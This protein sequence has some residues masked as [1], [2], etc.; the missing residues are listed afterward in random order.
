M[1]ATSFIS[2]SLDPDIDGVLSGIKWATP[3]LTFSFPTSGSFYGYLPDPAG[4]ETATFGLLD[5][6]AQAM[7]RASAVEKQTVLA[8]YAAVSGLIFTE[9]NESATIH[10]DLRYGDSELH[11]Q[12][13]AYYPANDVA[14]VGGD[15][16]MTKSPLF[17][18]PVKGNKAFFTYLHETG[19]ALGLKHGHETSLAT[20]IQ[21]TGFFDALP[22]SHDSMEYSVMTYRSFVGGPFLT[23]YSNATF[24]Y[25]QTLMQDDVAA[26]QYLYG[27][28]FA[29]NSGNSVYTWSATT[30]EMSING[31]AQGAPGSPTIFM[32]IWDGGGIDTYDLSTRTTNLVIN[33][34]PGGW[35]NLGAQLANL[36]LG[37]TAVGNISNSLLFQ[38]NTASLIENLIGGSGADTLTGNAANNVLNGGGG[39]DTVNVAYTYNVGYTITGSSTAANLVISGVNGTDTLLNVEFVHFADGTTVSSRTLVGNHAP[40]VTSDGAGGSANLSYAENG[41]AAVT[42]VTATDQDGDTISYSIAGGADA[43]Q[44]Q[45]NAATGALSFRAVPNFEAA[46]DADRNNSYLVQVAATDNGTTPLTDTQSLT[47]NVTNVATFTPPMLEL[48]AFGSG[49]AGGDWISQNTY[50]RE[51]ADINGDGK[52]DIVGFGYAGTYAALA[53]GNGKFAGPTFELAAFGAGPSGGDWISDN[54]YHR[55][56][57]DVNGDGK[58]DIVGFGYAGTYVALATSGGHFASPTFEL[59]AFGAGPAGGDWINNDTYHR[60][61]A[62]VNGDGKAD[63]VGFGHAG[64]YVALA[65]SGGHFA[66]PTFELAEFGAGPGG[67]DWFSDNIF[68]RELADVNGDGKADIVGFGYAGTYVALATAGGHF[69]ASTFEFAEF[70]TA[71]SA[72]GWANQ[73]TYHRELADVNGDGRADIVGFGAAGSYVSKATG[74]GHFGSASLELAAFG[75]AASAGSW[76][77]DNSYHRGLADVNGDLRADIVGFGAAGVYVSLVDDFLF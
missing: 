57:A 36:G 53:T 33:L 45:I 20:G 6:A 2:N 25:A 68:H 31:V 59:A 70:G 75:T 52:A 46:A 7:V 40:I 38:G 76:I 50:H 11:A 37:H 14:G 60:E 44:F 15:V 62:D 9:V 12:S 16:W 63:I 17:D 4:I 74:L 30:G 34:N 66:G 23:D 19:H 39:I 13:L 41:T 51:L 72:G 1:P 21:G 55:E 8:Q 22:T 3:A 58:A 5:P 47:I 77:S 18:A 49:P 73:D 69:A 48:A 71:A 43:A 67:G 26:I 28:N 24:D 61:L 10:G 32:N 65:T 42:N 54:T 35:V 56:L 29:S 27:A 64:T